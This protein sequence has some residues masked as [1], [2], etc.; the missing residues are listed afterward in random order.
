MSR[1][2]RPATQASSTPAVPTERKT[3]TPKPKTA[4]MI[5]AEA[6]LAL[7]KS[8][9]N[10]A[11]KLAD[12]TKIAKLLKSLTDAGKARV[13]ELIGDIKPTEACQATSYQQAAGP[14]E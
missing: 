10:E 11:E 14:Q 1:T 9:A 4:K 12:G 3:R 5:E 6:A 13:R 8:E 2:S 7:A